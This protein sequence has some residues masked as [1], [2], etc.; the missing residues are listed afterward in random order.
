MQISTIQGDFN[1][2]RF[3][4]YAAADSKYFDLYGRSLVNSVLRNTNFGVHLHLYDPRPQ[5]LEFCQQERVSVTWEKTTKHQFDSAVALWSRP[6]LPEPFAH[7]RSKMLGIKVVDASLSLQDNLDIWL[8]KTYYACMRF[9]RLHEFLPEPRKFLAIDIDGLVRAPF[10]IDFVDEEHQDIYVYEKFKID[11]NTKQQIMT[12]HLAGSILF[13]P[14]PEARQF[15]ADI[16]NGMR[17]EI[18]ADN[19]YWFLDQNVLDDVIARYRKGVLPI[20]YIDWHMNP[21]SA[22][23][24][25]KGKRKDLEVFQR[26][27]AIYR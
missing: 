21:A 16:A 6:D 12:G 2:D 8:R 26:E 14:K 27:L 3:F 15:L 22:I 25:A 1:Q 4:I 23:W 13:T 11:R 9:V 5:Q 24:T 19:I 17:T 7:R 18:E 20:S 10:P